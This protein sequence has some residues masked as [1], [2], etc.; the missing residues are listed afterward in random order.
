MLQLLV[1]GVLATRVG[2]IWPGPDQNRRS[3]DGLGCS[4][5][6]KE[7]P[8]RSWSTR[9]VFVAENLAASTFISRAL[10][11]P[12]VEPPNAI[13]VEDLIRIFP[14]LLDPQSRR[15][16]GTVTSS[17]SVALNNRSRGCADHNIVTARPSFP[18]PRVMN[19]VF[20]PTKQLVSVRQQWF[21]TAFVVF[22]NK[23]YWAKHR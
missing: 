18:Q 17:A 8:R 9:E 19:L 4:I 11:E 5:T 22:G 14:D 23:P 3:A 21:V 10:A 7:V 20:F 2:I 15:V 12:N 6:G 13:A 1:P 16:A